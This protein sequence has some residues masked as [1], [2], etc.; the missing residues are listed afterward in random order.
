MKYTTGALKN[1]L[2]GS[3]NPSLY[4]ALAGMLKAMEKKLGARRLEFLIGGASLQDPAVVDKVKVLDPWRSHDGQ[5]FLARARTRRLEV[6]A[7]GK[8]RFCA[9]QSR[10]VSSLDADRGRRTDA[11]MSDLDP[12]TGTVSEEIMTLPKPGNP[13]QPIDALDAVYVVRLINR[14]PEGIRRGDSHSS[15]R[16]FSAR[17]KSGRLHP[18]RFHG[19]RRHV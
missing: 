16:R 6:S 5:D 17:A 11:R 9:V 3:V 12:A 13:Q 8:Y 7:S 19:R 10:R 2:T 4:T 14:L 15:Y 18:P 1:E